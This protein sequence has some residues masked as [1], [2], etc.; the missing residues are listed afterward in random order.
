MTIHIPE[1]LAKGHGVAKDGKSFSESAREIGANW[2]ERFVAYG[3]LTGNA[4]ILDVGCGPGRMAIAIGERFGWKNRYLGFD[5]KAADIDFS[6]NAITSRYANFEFTW[7]DVRSPLYN[8]A[9]TIEPFAVRF[10][11]E[12]ESFDFCFATSVFTHL[13]AGVV[14][15]YIGE[16]ARSLRR[17][18]TFLFTAFVIQPSYSADQKPRFR[19]HLGPDSTTFV[20]DS[21]VAEEAIGFDFGYLQNLLKTAGFDNIKHYTGGWTGNPDAIA[22]QD[23]IVCQKSTQ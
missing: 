11:C 23:I 12:D 5:I 6:R 16:A 17:E 7:L 10:P 18:G 20:T 4:S 19:F 22:G 3:G 15:L 9:G 14:S 8:P 1:H 21:E 2:A 13:Y